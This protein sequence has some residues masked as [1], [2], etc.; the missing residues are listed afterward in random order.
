MSDILDEEILSR[1]EG[2]S[3]LESIVTFEK[4]E[5]EYGFR[6]C[7]LPLGIRLGVIFM[8]IIAFFNLRGFF[9]TVLS[10]AAISW[11]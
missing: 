6:G 4:G 9:K 10:C 1:K 5:E 2:S 7:I 3:A 8:L 11:S